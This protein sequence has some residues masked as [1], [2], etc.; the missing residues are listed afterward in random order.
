MAEDS[1]F[2]VRLGEELHQ[3]LT[4]AARENRVSM[5]REVVRRLT[6]SFEPRAFDRN[7]TAAVLLDALDR[8]GRLS[9]SLFEGGVTEEARMVLSVEK[10]LLRLTHVLAKPEE[11]P[12]ALDDVLKGQDK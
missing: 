5:N 8:L 4:D 12:T 9:D 1:Q 7:M 10:T 6:E 3:R 11:S 2:R